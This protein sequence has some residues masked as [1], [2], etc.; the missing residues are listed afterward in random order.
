M[1]SNGLYMFYVCK[2]VSFHK[3]IQC[4]MNNHEIKRKGV[5][6]VPKVILTLL[7]TCRGTVIFLE[8]WAGVPALAVRISA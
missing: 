5:K 2:L 6:W 7:K 4:E 8:Q 1:H 3:A